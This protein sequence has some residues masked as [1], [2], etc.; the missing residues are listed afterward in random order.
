MRVLEVPWLY[1]TAT[2]LSNLGPVRCPARTTAY[3]DSNYINASQLACI[4]YLFQGRSMA[5]ESHLARKQLDGS[6]ST[7]LN[8]II[9]Y[10]G[11]MQYVG[12]SIQVVVIQ[13]HAPAVP[14]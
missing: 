8:S 10:P 12:L 13:G 14:E 2:E 11:R 5:S 3:K 9:R 1:C 7:A 4:A 6:R